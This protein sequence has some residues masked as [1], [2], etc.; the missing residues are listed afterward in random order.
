M[1]FR[2][3]GKLM[4]KEKT[5]GC[6][7]WRTQVQQA[8]AKEIVDFAK[9]H[10]CEYTIKS[11]HQYPYWGNQDNGFKRKKFKEIFNEH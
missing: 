7:E 8:P 3:G 9:V 2:S 6:P 4:E 1:G 5:K 10:P 11:L